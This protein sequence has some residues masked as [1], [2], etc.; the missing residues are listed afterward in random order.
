MT[1][2]ATLVSRCPVTE[3][4]TSPV[5]V[6]PSSMSESVTLGASSSP[7]LSVSSAPEACAL[8]WRWACSRAVAMALLAS[9]CE[10]RGMRTTSVIL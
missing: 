9:C 7:S 4:L 2:A 3:S 8:L 5:T 10:A 1:S 6:E